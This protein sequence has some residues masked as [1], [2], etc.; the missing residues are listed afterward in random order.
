MLAFCAKGRGLTVSIKPGSRHRLQSRAATSLSCCR[1]LDC[2]CKKRSAAVHGLGLAR[3]ADGACVA[4]GLGDAAGSTSGAADNTPAVCLALYHR[5]RCLPCSCC[6]A[7]LPFMAMLL[8]SASACCHKAM[9]H[10]SKSLHLPKNTQSPNRCTTYSIARHSH[11]NLARRSPQH[12]GL[13]RPRS[14]HC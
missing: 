13:S 6:H 2:R 12:S 1:L 4:C 10:G 7:Q 8:Y 14:H 5:G 9:H 3:T 11:A